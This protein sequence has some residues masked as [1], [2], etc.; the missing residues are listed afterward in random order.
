MRRL[1]ALILFAILATS[2]PAQ[3]HSEP[4]QKLVDCESNPACEGSVDDHRW[5]VHV[6]YLY[7]FL[8]RLRVPPLV[9]VGPRGSS[10]RPGDPGVNVLN[11]DR[12]TSRHIRYIGVRGEI[13][14]WADCEHNF[15]F[16]ATAFFLERDSTYLTIPWNTF[17]TLAI[18]YV[19]ARDGS[20]QARIVA[21]R[22]PKLGDLSG[23]TVLY[24]R[25]EFFGQEANA[26]FRCL[27]GDD[28]DLHWLAGGRFLQLR[29]R[30]DLISSSKILPAESTVIGLEDHFSTFNKFYGGQLGLTGEYR[31]GRFFVDG[32]AAVAIGVND[33]MVR[34][35]GESIFHV[36]GDRQTQQYGL[37]IL[38][39]NRGE[40]ERWILDVVTELRINVGVELTSWL[41]IHAGYSLI[42][43]QNPVRPGDQIEPV[44]LTQVRPGGL[45]GPAQPTL[46]WRE[47]LFW[48][49]GVNVGIECRW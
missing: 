27:C 17:P 11:E 44:N 35:K 33:Q 28:F 4:S 26:L 29:E 46:P 12:L 18:P 43:W 19:D 32:K 41:R 2:A 48:A 24:S 31:C 37:F 6:D 45:T 36:P 7:W 30:L 1:V 16:Q 38:P 42:T 34:L 20:V 13:D 10:G 23:S 15:G 14:W 49:H 47:D 5:E 9:A 22:D 21:G 25:M 40:Y 8:H 39:S 3:E